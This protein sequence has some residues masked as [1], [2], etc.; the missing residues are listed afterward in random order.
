MNDTAARIRADLCV[1]GSGIAA[2]NA[3]AV[4]SGYLREGQQVVLI[5]QRPRLRIEIPY[6][7]QNSEFTG[8]FVPIH[9]GAEVRIE[10]AP[11]LLGRPIAAEQ[12]H[13]LEGA[14]PRDAEQMS[15]LLTNCP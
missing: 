7:L 13:G 12:R 15:Q 11:R 10:V 2:L 4:A 14:D 9:P 5:E 6:Q 3:L 1:V 8:N